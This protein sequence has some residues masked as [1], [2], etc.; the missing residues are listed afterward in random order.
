M[1]T[2]PRDSGIQISCQ[3]NKETIGIPPGSGTVSK[4]VKGSGFRISYPEKPRRSWG[5]H[6]EVRPDITYMK[7]NRSRS[8]VQG[9]CPN[10]SIAEAYKGERRRRQE[11]C[12]ANLGIPETKGLKDEA[13]DQRQWGITVWPCT[14]VRIPDLAIMLTSSG[15]YGGR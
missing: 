10:R 2:G 6:Q 3:K 14:P 13:I 1:F 7:T 15:W 12:T 9:W 11:K 4:R 8:N 5:L